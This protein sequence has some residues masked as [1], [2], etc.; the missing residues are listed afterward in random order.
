MKGFVV[1]GEIHAPI[2][3]LH[4]G[5]SDATHGP[6]HDA[7]HGAG[8]ADAAGERPCEKQTGDVLQCR[9]GR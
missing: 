4:T 2:F 1:Y 6:A 7:V 5:C 3:R 8:P 9:R